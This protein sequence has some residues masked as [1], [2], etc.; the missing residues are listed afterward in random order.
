M[1][2]SDVARPARFALLSG[3]GLVVLLVAGAVAGLLLGLVAA[4]N[5]PLQGVDERVVDAANGLVPASPVLVKALT[6]LT[7]FGGSPA[8][9]LVVAVLAVALLVRRLPRLAAYAVVTGVGAAALSSGTKA[10]VRR[11]RPEVDL[12]VS[13]APGFSFPSG[14]SLG[15]AVTFGLLLL[16]LW[17]RVPPRGRPLAVV[18]VVV[19][20]GVIGV[21]RVLLGVHYP[22][23]VVGGWAMGVLWLAVTAVAFRAWRHREGLTRADDDGL[24]TSPDE[25]RA[26]DPAP[27]HDRPLPHPARAAAV[28]LVTAVTLWGGLVLLGEVVTGWTSLRAAEAAVVA[29]VVD[30]R[31]GPLTAVLSVAGL[32]GDTAGAV[33]AAAVASALAVVL[34]RR[35]APGLVVLLALVGESLV[36]LATSTVVARARP[37]LDPT[38]AELPP[39]SYSFPSGHAAAAVALYGTV[40]LLVLAWVR[41]RPLRVA[42]VT[43]CAVV[44]LLVALERVYSG[45]HFPS[46]LLGSLVLGGVWV[47]ACWSVTQ[48]ARGAPDAPRVL[49]REP[50]RAGA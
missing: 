45:A 16:V 33:A 17:P 28:L 3:L 6:V 23:D 8:L 12:P 41:S 32:L 11:L 19:T 21:T 30:L 4:G 49:A 5:E 22:S 39:T 24:A 2:S 20:V 25:R 14:H 44:V 29:A 27:E 42:G 48:P 47:A 46:D 7:W 26:L 38:A 35:W 9:T 31:T 34:T 13:E 37:E 50:V 1:E 43:A 40:A 10:L 36:F 18:A 15:S